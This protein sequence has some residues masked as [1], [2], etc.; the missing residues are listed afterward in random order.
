MDGWP[1][2]KLDSLMM[3]MMMMMMMVVVGGGGDGDLECWNF[4]L[5]LAQLN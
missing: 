5:W 2:L 4:Q 3:M 1:G